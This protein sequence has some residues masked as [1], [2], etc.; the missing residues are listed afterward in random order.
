MGALTLSVYFITKLP[1]EY[2]MNE[3]DI[4]FFFG[5]SNGNMG[6]LLQNIRSSFLTVDSQDQFSAVYIRDCK[7]LRR[8]KLVPQNVPYRLS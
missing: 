3:A 5:F 8:S 6:Q 2:L 7:R 1:Y 4:N